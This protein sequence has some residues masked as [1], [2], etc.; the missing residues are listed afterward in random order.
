MS[1]AVN[2]GDN[3]VISYKTAPSDQISLELS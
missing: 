1:F 3:A 2:G